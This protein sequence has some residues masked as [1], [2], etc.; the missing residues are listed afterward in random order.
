MFKLDISVAK[1]FCLG[2]KSV[3]KHRPLLMAIE[4]IDNSSYVLSH[5]YFMT[6]STS[7][8]LLLTEQNWIESN[9][10]WWWTNLDK[11]ELMVKKGLII[12]NCVVIKCPPRPGNNAQI[13]IVR[14]M[15][16]NSST[17]SSV[18]GRYNVE[19]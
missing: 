15:T 6:S 9:T 11:E 18:T 10:K 19:C 17:T 2:T 1:A 4:D 14:D 3:D 5:C 16:D 12:H 7:C 13:P 8:S